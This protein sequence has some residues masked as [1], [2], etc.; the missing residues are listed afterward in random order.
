MA[1]IPTQKQIDSLYLLLTQLRRE[2]IEVRLIRFAKWSE[3]I[4]AQIMEVLCLEDVDRY[5]VYFDSTIEQRK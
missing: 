3:N 4:N 2:K 1:F 5:L